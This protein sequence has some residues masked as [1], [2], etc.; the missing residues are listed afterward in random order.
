MWSLPTRERGLKLKVRVTNVDAAQS[1]PTRERGLK[2][3]VF[4]LCL[5]ALASLPTR[6]RGLKRHHAHCAAN[7]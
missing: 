4:S 2:L 5:I 6:E 3:R 7:I 1:L